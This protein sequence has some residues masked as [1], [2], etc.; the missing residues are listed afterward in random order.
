[1][2]AVVENYRHLSLITE[3]MREAAMLGEWDQLVELEQQCNIHV[4][5]MKQLDLAPLDEAARKQKVDLINK[6]L[7]DD[8]AI[9]E[10]TM[11][12]MAKLQHLIQSSRSEQRLLQTYGRNT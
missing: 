10:Q 8:A 12:W 1:M 6:I 5:S 7:A 2:N 9:R 3:Q 11:P 4:E